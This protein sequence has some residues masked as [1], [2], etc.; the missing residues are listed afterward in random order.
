MSKPTCL[1]SG[2]I[3]LDVIYKEGI[4]KPF[5]FAGGSCGNVLTILSYFNW[6]SYP[7]MRLGEDFEGKRIIEDMSKWNVKNTFIEKEINIESP[8][9]IERVFTSNKPKHYFNV[10]CDHGKWLP[11]RKPYLLKSLK[12]IFNKLPITNVFYFDVP[13]PSAIKLAQELKKQNTIIFFEPSKF[14]DNENF[15][16]ALRIS[17]IVKH[18]YDKLDDISATNIKIPLEIK[19]KG[20]QGLYYK[21]KFLKQK[22]WRH[23]KAYPTTKLVDAAGS[24]D[25][26]SAGLIHMLFKNNSK[27]LINQKQLE[28]ALKFGQALASL[29][30]NFVG[31]RGIMYN[32]EKHKIIQLT[33][34]LINNNVELPVIKY[35]K[36]QFK[37]KFANKCTICTCDAYTSI[38][39]TI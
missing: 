26:L 4:I 34:R 1:G 27:L 8:R 32:M 2:M 11:Q 24:G 25:W 29:N 38:H 10:K 19:T 12:N 39:D 15:L 35:K 14:I 28:C 30:C 9:I 22:K 5:F 33:N 31:S 20:D 17:D 7:L 3:A 13:T 37:S 6:N 21:C 23:L 16:K 18:C 36:I